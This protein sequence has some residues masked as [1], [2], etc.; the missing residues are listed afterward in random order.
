MAACL[1]VTGHQG[2]AY[3]KK[4]TNQYHAA[5]FMFQVA[6]FTDRLF[7]CLLFHYKCLRFCKAIFKPLNW[8]NVLCI[9]RLLTSICWS[10]IC[11]A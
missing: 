9:H 11:A 1:L 5:Q 6:P 8:R 2:D 10:L 4:V 3:K 7:H